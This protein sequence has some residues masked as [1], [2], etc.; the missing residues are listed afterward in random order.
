M[1]DFCILVEYAAAKSVIDITLNDFESWN[2]AFL[3]SKLREKIVM[4]KN[5]E[6]IEAGFFLRCLVE[7]YRIE[8]SNRYRYISKLCSEFKDSKKGGLRFSSFMSV[9]NK[10]TEISTET[11]IKLYRDCYCLTRGAITPESIFIVCSE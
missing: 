8:R 6:Y 3:T 2:I 10:F 11:K 4:K 1:G 5:K 7:Y 9:I